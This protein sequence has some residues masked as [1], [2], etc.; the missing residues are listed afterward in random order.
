MLTRDAILDAA[1]ELV[2][3]DG[4]DK[5][6][7]RPLAERLGVTATAIYH[8]FDGRDAVIEALVDRVCST[9]VSDS[10]GDG[11]WDVRLTALLTTMVDQAAAHPATAAWIITTYAR[12]PPML[13]LHE[14]MLEILTDAG[15]TPEDAVQIKG[16]MLRL[17]IGHLM[18][19]EA[20]PGHEWRKL[21][22]NSF[23]CYRAAG[24]ALDAFDPAAHFRLA[25]DALLVG[26][27]DRIGP[28]RR[29]PRRGTSAK[30]A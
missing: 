17:C 23:P 9:I 20:A 28:P 14:A 21:P 30:R 18:L 10:A 5:L 19:R 12:R 26:L 6:T 16:A 4:S 29:R 27:Q 13:Q 3:R 25:L 24:P 8:Y 15:F 11:P 2:D 7:M 1:L 22:K